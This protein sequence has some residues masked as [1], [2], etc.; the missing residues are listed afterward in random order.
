MRQ[1]R[2]PV[3]QVPAGTPFAALP[4]HWRCPQCDGDADQFMVID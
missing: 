2:D 1:L 3:W 4:E